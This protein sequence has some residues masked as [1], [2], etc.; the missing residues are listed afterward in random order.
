[1]AGHVSFADQLKRQTNP[2]KMGQYSIASY[3][4]CGTEK[5]MN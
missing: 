1:M 3:L 4:V 5:L 2:D